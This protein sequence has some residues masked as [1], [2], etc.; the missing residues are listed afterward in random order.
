MYATVWFD[1][2]DF[3]KVAVYRML[4]KTKWLSGSDHSR[5][6]TDEE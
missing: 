3:L 1:F 6:A 5:D 2:N 4:D